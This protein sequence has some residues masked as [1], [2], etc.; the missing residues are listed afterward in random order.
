MDIIDEKGRLFGVV[1]VVDA[2]VVLLVL[3]LV[4]AGVAL[5]L[6]SDSDP[7][8]SDEL[9]N[10]STHA[11]LDLG[12]Q[13]EYI[14]AQL[15]EGDTYSP[16]ED[17]NLTVTDVHLEP[18]ANG[19]AA[20]LLRV[21]LEGDPASESFQYDGAPPRLGRELQVVTDQYQVNGVV[22]GTGEA[23]AVETTERGVLVAGTVP[24]DTA[25]EI[26]EG[27]AFTL[28]ER[29]VATVESVEVFGTDEP[30]RK[31]VRLGL[32]LDAR[33]TS[34]G[35]QFAGERLAEGAE[36][37][38]RTD[39]Y[40]LSLA[41]QRVGATEPRG[42]PATR[43]VTL[44]IEDADPG[45]ATA[46][47]AGMTESVNDRTVATLT[48]VQRERS[49]VILVSEDGDVYERDHP[50]NL[51]VTM[52]ADLSVRETGGGLT[53]KGESLQYGSTVTL[54]L[55]SVTVEATVASL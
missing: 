40:G 2:L 14:L 23:D 32:T 24:A 10:A 49:T 46:I 51:D 11:T 35:T 48:D 13:P 21:R 9:D 6:G 55:G 50:R 39:D 16:G 28:R 4:A 29:T 18:R 7:A 5:V 27:D 52:T 43:T 42:E 34:E 26:R 53:F 17:D 38:F 36:I 54:D 22:T 3:A 15:E 19:D 12:T 33:Q 20:A 30:D 44:Q 41:V 25:S 45:L 1:N 37:P 31:R 8:Q 47:E